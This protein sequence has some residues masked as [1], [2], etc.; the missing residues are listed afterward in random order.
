MSVNFFFK[1]WLAQNINFHIPCILF[2]HL[3]FRNIQS[4]QDK[5]FQ[6]DKWWSLKP[7]IWTESESHKGF[8]ASGILS[9][10]IYHK[11]IY[12]SKS[13]ANQPWQK[14]SLKS[15][16]S[17]Q[18]HFSMSLLHYLRIKIDLELRR[19]IISMNLSP[20]IYKMKNSGKMTSKVPSNWKVSQPQKTEGRRTKIHR[21]PSTDE[22]LC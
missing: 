19:W 9:E 5:C 21:R 10:V 4:A 13:L 16:T 12:R 18:L 11:E 2:Q 22:A 8:S 20:L 3:T 1:L 14:E 17:V 7:N 6:R 15:S